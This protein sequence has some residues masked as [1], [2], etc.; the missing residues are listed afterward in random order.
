MV[1]MRS[2]AENFKKLVGIEAEPEFWD[3]EKGHIKRFAQA[4]GDENPIYYDEE[5]AKK[6]RYGGIV[7]PPF[8]LIDAGLVKLVDRLVAMCPELANINGSTEIEFYRPMMV[9]DRIKTVAKLADVEEKVGK[10]GP[11]IFLTIEVT[12]TNQRQEIVAKC[13]NIFIRR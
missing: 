12:Y 8:F 3:V 1:D 10:S 7:A 11:M 5:Y 6:T 13:R 2:I 4:I 9:A